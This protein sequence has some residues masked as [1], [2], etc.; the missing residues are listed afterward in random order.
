MYFLMDA[1]RSMLRAL[2]SVKVNSKE[3]AKKVTE[4][5]KNSIV[6]LGLFND[7]EA[8]P[9]TFVNLTASKLVD[10]INVANPEDKSV[11]FNIS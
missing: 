7:K 2:D 6:G 4:T 10:N 11:S 3:L 9:F 1:S 8:I 5:W